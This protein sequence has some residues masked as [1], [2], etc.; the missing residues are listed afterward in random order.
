MLIQVCKYRQGLNSA[1]PHK[2]LV[3]VQSVT[4]VALNLVLNEQVG[5]RMDSNLEQ[6]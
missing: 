3:N 6:I 4:A 1:F 2:Q 5:K